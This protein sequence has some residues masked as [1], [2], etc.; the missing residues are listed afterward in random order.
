MG[1]LLCVNT[2][3]HGCNIFLDCEICRIMNL[4]YKLQP[5]FPYHCIQLSNL[6]V[7]FIFL[8]LNSCKNNILK[9]IHPCLRS[10]SLGVT[11]YLLILDAV[12]IYLSFMI[13]TGNQVTCAFI[14]CLVSHLQFSLS[15]M[16]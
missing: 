10:C 14:S 16:L 2:I 7:P 13:T 8:Q 12:Y 15:F 3:N 9:S 4:Y 1:S 6:D 11:L 5:E